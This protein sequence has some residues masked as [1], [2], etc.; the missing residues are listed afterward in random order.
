[1][2]STNYYST[3]RWRLKKGY[4]ETDDYL[5]EELSESEW[6]PLF[7]KLMRNRMIMGAF[8][9]GK[10]HEKNKP[11]YDR[12][13]SIITRINSYQETG[14]TEF[15][16]DVANLCIIE[17]EEGRHHAKHFTSIDDGEHVKE[18]QEGEKLRK[19]DIKT[20]EGVKAGMV[21]TSE[22]LRYLVR[23]ISKNRGGLNL[24]K[25]EDVESFATSSSALVK[26]KDELNRRSK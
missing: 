2:R 17:F 18:A 14:N 15:L 22:E 26:I 16:V 5:R 13:G 8:R 9:Y 1:M 6:S 7:E 21:F 12:V 10:L 19:A 4:A 3:H 24:N 20:M 11:K 23:V 25:D